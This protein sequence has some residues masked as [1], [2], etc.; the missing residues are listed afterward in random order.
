[1]IKKLLRC[2][3]YIRVSTTEQMMHGKSLQAQREFLSKY[4]SEHNMT[5]VGVFADEGKTAR[6]ELKKRKAIHDLLDCVKAGEIDV[7]LFWKM[8]RWFRSVSDFYKVQDIL[9]EHDVKWI[10]V[11]EPSINMDT[12]E[13][14]LNLNILLSIGQN[15]V[16]TTSERIKFTNASMIENGRVIF[17]D[18]NMPLGYMVGIVDGVKRMIKNPK[19]EELVNE[20]FRYFRAH[21]KKRATML[22]IQEMF[23]IDFSYTQLR[24]ML[25]SEFYVGKYRNNTNYC[26]AYLTLEEWNEIQEISAR[27]IRSTPSGRVYLFSGMIRCPECGQILC[28]TGCSSIINRKTGEKRTYCYYRC[29]RAMIDSLCSYRH[30]LSQNLIEKYLLDNLEAEYTKYQMRLKKASEK[31]EKQKKKQRTAASIKREMNNLNLMFQKERISWDYYDKE[32]TKLEKELASSDTV[33]PMSKRN[34]SYLNSVFQGDFLSMYNQL[35]A[36]GKQEF[37]RSII[38]QILIDD[39]SNII[40]VDFL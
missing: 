28:G 8:D 21:Q 30:R 14:R 6:K 31:V 37:W 12:R 33:V 23:G 20:V 16:D 22:H 35:E 26:P 39:E 17:S 24:T 4:A 27:N 25:S 11:A 7:I 2:A 34:L 9:D 36:T 29:N 19:E 18:A 15:E 3:I 38:K 13:G 5:I 1:M 10:A 32:Y 40:G